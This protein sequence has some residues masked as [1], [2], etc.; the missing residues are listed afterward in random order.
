VK[1][2]GPNTGE[3]KYGPGTAGQDTKGGNGPAIARAY[4]KQA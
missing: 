3:C 2:G 4:V 1:A